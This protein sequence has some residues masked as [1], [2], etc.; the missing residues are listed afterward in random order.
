MKCNNQA[1]SN[2]WLDQYLG[3]GG[4]L[5]VSNPGNVKEHPQF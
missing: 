5:R 3:V 1:F 2:Y 4:P